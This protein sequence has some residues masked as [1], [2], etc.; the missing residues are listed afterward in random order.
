MAPVGLLAGSVSGADLAAADRVV[1]A[2]LVASSC[3][4]A[5]LLEQARHAE[6]VRIGWVG[7]TRV[8]FDQDT[9]RLTT[10]LA[11]VRDHLRR[12]AGTLADAADVAAIHAESRCIV[13][14]CHAPTSTST[15]THA[16]R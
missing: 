10:E 6:S 14:V 7:V 15:T 11:T 8:L 13:G 12:A 5:L 16:A 9:A 4:D 3:V 1:Q 2:L